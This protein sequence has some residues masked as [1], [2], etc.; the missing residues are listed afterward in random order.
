[1][2]S[3]STVAD[4]SPAGAVSVPAWRWIVIVLA[5]A[6]AS[7]CVTTFVQLQNPRVLVSWHGF[8]HTA[9]ANRFPGPFR[10]P[11]NPFFAGER[12]PYYWL[13]HDLAAVIGQALQIHVLHAFQMLT[14]TGLVILWMSAGAIGVHRFGS[15]KAGLLAGFLALAGV[16][17]LGPAIAV[18]RHF[19]QGRDLFTA[20]RPTDT[21]FV[22]DDESEELMLQPVIPALYVSADWRRGE[23]IAWYLD[24]S[25][26]GV[27]VGL[28]FSL[29]FVFT[30]RTVSFS[31]VMAAGIIAAVMTA[32]NPLIG[33][34]S[35]ASL[36]AGSVASR[37]FAWLRCESV[38]TAPSPLRLA[39]S[40]V[41]GAAIA[42]P[43][44]YH[45]FLVGGSGMTLFASRETLL[46]VVALALN[47]VILLPMAVGG[48]LVTRDPLRERWLVLVIAA[49]GLLC[50]VPFI[51]LTDDTEHNLANTAQALLVIPGVAVV[52]AKRIRW[53][54]P[55][56]LF[57]VC[58]PMTVATLIGYLGRPPLPVGF[59]GTVMHRTSDDS[60][61]R[62]YGWIREST[63]GD[64]VFVADPAT[65]AKMSGNVAELPAFTGRTLFVDQAS[66][67]TTPHADFERRRVLAS[68]LVEGTRILADDASYIAALRRPVYVISYRA[69]QP[70]M[71]DRLRRVYGDSVFHDRFA[72]VFILNLS[73]PYGP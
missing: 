61:D 46:R 6:A 39:V 24:N 31:A 52:M 26:R 58:L 23:N 68:R 44:Y 30:S 54:T 66:Y 33:L 21:V 5:V 7:V 56:L 59:D 49:C 60:L 42:S 55:S 36:F 22:S 18:T 16:N 64:A 72:A 15:L 57:G 70:E 67:L 37:L 71:A 10:T 32:L 3:S 34:A 17:P 2:R 27:A 50:V 43:T 51:S 28:L 53:L 69:D 45:L 63:P 4:D 48:I 11:E 20:P 41:V 12:L 29:L 62:L 13:H 73:S 38:R 19:L 40:G 35:V 14:A 47:V 1:V 25:S 8:L 9:I 65:P